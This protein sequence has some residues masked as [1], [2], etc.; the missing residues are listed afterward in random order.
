MAELDLTQAAEIATQLARE[1]GAILS[2]FQT[3]PFQ[4]IQKSNENDI[5]TEA[6]RGAEAVIIAGL[7]QHFPDHYLVGEESGGVGESFENAEYLWYID[8]L[9]GTTNFANHIPAFSVSI[10]LV[11]SQHEPLVGVVYA[12]L[13]NEMFLAI[14]GQGVTLNGQPIK[15]GEKQT[16]GSCVVASGFPYIKATSADNNLAEWAAMLVRTRDLRRFGSAALDLCYVAAGRFDG[17]WEQLINP[18]DFLAGVLCV[19]EAG[20]TASDYEGLTNGGFY[21][22]RRV[23][24][25]NPNIH[26]Q[27]L[28]VIQEARADLPE[29]SV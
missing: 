26:A 3:R 29:K 12:P 27:M 6:D 24:A 15:V 7:Q 5:V 21:Q 25:A 16:L 19:Q 10:A 13:F 4:Q 1:A 18:W 2:D 28:K 9:D 8:P 22:G 11:N 14:R 17:Y 20:G 23:V